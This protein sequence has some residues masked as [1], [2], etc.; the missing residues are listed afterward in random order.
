MDVCLE[1]ANT[2]VAKNALLIS[3]N[4]PFP[5]TRRKCPICKSGEAYNTFEVIFEG[6]YGNENKTPA[7]NR[8]LG[9]NRNN[10]SEIK[11]MTTEYID[12]I[13]KKSTDDGEGEFQETFL[14]FDVC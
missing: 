4:T 9:Y 3:N 8:D 1:H 7:D 5:L 11:E 12:Y 14:L 2:S 13:Y 6:P 10:S